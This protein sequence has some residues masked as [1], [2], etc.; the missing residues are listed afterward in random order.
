MTDKP[1]KGTVNITQEILSEARSMF[2]NTKAPATDRFIF[3]ME[4]AYYIDN[5]GM[6]EVLETNKNEISN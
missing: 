1:S 3:T 5:K 4:G 6:V 2:N